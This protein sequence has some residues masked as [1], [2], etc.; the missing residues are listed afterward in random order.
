M[1]RRLSEKSFYRL[2]AGAWFAAA[3]GVVAALGA[4]AFSFYPEPTTFVLARSVLIVMLITG[5]AG[6]VLGSWALDPRAVQS[7]LPAAL[8]GVAVFALS[9]CIS[10][11][12]LL[13][14]TYLGM[15]GSH[16]GSF[17][18]SLVMMTAGLG[19]SLGWLL[20]ALGALSGWLL[21][22]QREWI[23]RKFLP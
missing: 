23:R 21:F 2:A 3:G 5:A 6:A 15:E 10:V 13:A 14:V 7:A 22:R 16:L 17:G 8:L 19:L 4:S 1:G 12:T 11:F 9:S 20:A 18:Y